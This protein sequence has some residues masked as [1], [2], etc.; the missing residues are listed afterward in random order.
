MTRG[1]GAVLRQAGQSGNPATNAAHNPALTAQAQPA[2]HPVHPSQ[3][4][5]QPPTVDVHV[6]RETEAAHEGAPGPLHPQVPL[7]LAALLVLALALTRD[8][9]HAVWGDLRVRRGEEGAGGAGEAGPS[10]V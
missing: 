3:P 10:E 6:F 9:Q 4:A 8:G 7:L 5:R 1:G 2:S